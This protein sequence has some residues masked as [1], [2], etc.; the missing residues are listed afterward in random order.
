MRARLKCPHA[1]SAVSFRQKL[2]LGSVLHTQRA[3][4]YNPELVLVVDHLNTN[5][6]DEPPE[7]GE[8][9]KRRDGSPS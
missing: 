5:S 3:N 2:P 7:P 6:N 8:E 1:G 4:R 9:F